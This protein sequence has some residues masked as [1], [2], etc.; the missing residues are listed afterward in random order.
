M[1]LELKKNFDFNKIK[2]N[3]M[4]SAW[5][6]TIA[7]H[8]NKSIQEGLEKSI[9][10]DGKPF[11]PVSEFTKKSIQDK[12]PH[13]KPLVRSGRMGETR[14]KLA[15]RKKLSFQIRSGIKKSK[16]RWNVEVDGKKSSGSRKT[17]GYNYGAFHQPAAGEGFQMI[18]Y[19]SKDSLIP[20]KKVPLRKWFGI[21]KPMLPDGSQWKKF[22]LQFD[23]T[24]QRFLTTAMKKFGK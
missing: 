8:I 3:Q 22:A 12:K 16:A 23:L 6:N 17:K 4:S 24:F 19:T 11:A 7:K 2:I 1:K 21:P 14:K 5:L 18:N 9:D 13:K 15:T 10:L 20:N